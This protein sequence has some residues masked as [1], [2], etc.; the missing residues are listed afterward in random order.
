MSRGEEAQKSRQTIIAVSGL[1]YGTQFDNTVSVRSDW[2][3]SLLGRCTRKSCGP[4]MSPCIRN[5][6]E[7]FVLSPGLSTIEPMVGVGG[8]HPS[9]ISM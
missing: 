1:N 7:R 8:Q 4:P 6:I 9:L 5:C 3:G 2:L